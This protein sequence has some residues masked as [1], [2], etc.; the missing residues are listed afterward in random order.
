[1][2]NVINSLK[3]VYGYSKKGVSKGLELSDKASEKF[4]YPHAK[5]KITSKK[6]LRKDRPTLVIEDKEIEGTW[7]DESRF[8]K[9]KLS[10]NKYL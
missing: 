5:K 1:M 3:K 2:V 10:R 9:S 4:I 7:D 6:I 8:F